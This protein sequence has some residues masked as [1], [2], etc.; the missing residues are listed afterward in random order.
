[1][2]FAVLADTHANLPALDAVLG[3]IR[4]EGC[5]EIIHLGDAIGIGPYPTECLDL[6]LKTP[7]TSMIMGNHETYLAFGLPKSSESWQNNELA[8]HRWV[9]QQIHPPLREAVVQFPYRMTRQV[10]DIRVLFLH[11]PLDDSGQGFAPIPG[12]PTPRTLDDLFAPGEERIVFYGHT[13]K[14][15]DIKGRARYVNPGCLG[16]N[17]EPIAPFVFLD[18]DDS[19]SYTIEKRVVAYDDQELFEEFRHRVVPDMKNIIRNFFKRESI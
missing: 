12:D 13:H 8:H 3:E 1:M 18:L 14:Q 11:Y 16:I 4:R 17:R 15:S 2:R 5:D 19:G 6:L 10:E 7:R 9:H